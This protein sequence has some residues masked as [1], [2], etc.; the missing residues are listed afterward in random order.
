M[1]PLKYYSPQRTPC[2]PS[3]TAKFMRIQ[4]EVGSVNISF[5]IFPIRLGRRH[6][7]PMIAT[8]F[9]YFRAL[10]ERIKMNQKIVKELLKQLQETQDPK[11]KINQ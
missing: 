7:P 2:S 1:L 9:Q 10:G 5:F 8:P 11:T 3:G 4:K 6:H